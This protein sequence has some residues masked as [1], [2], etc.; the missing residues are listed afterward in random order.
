MVRYIVGT[1]AEHE[2]AEG[3]RLP[4][5]DPEEMKL[6]LWLAAA[7]LPL[8]AQPKLL[9]NAQVDTRAAAAGPGEQVPERCRAAQPQPAW[10]G[11]TRRWRRDG[12]WDA[13]WSARTGGGRRAWCTWKRRIGW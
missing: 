10:I 4:D 11:Y 8:A 5:G 13:S 6:A 1:D 9:V 3:G 2:V 7:V 12:A